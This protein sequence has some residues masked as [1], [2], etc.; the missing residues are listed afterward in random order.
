MANDY[1]ILNG[2]VYPAIKVDSQEYRELIAKQSN[3]AFSQELQTDY[4]SHLEH[5]DAYGKWHD[6]LI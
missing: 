5:N 1:I 4:E 6:S 3:D 2:K